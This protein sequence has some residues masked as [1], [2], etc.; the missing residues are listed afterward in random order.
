MEF[1]NEI[2]EQFANIIDDEYFLQCWDAEDDDETAEAI[3]VQMVE[4]VVFDPNV[5]ASIL[6]DELIE[7]AWRHIRWHEIYQYYK[8]RAKEYHGAEYT[9]EPT[10]YSNLE[11]AYIAN[12]YPPEEYDEWSMIRRPIDENSIEDAIRG[13]IFSLRHEVITGWLLNASLERVQWQ[14]LLTEYNRLKK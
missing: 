7:Y 8:Q 13:D 12:A 6:Q 10:V 1:T 11:T 2:T 3:M 5:N 9:G 14:E 4:D